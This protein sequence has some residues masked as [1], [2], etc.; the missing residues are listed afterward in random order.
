MDYEW[1][2]NFKANSMRIRE[3]YIYQFKKIRIALNNNNQRKIKY[4][5]ILQIK[6]TDI[7]ILY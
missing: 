1:N 5:V 2:Q 4:K 3:E 7:E 6:K